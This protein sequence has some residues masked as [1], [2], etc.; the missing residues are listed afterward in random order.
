MY[1]DCLAKADADQ[2][3]TEVSAKLVRAENGVVNNIVASSFA[4]VFKELMISL[5]VS[6]MFLGLRFYTIYTKSMNQLVG[7][8]RPMHVLAHCQSN[9]AVDVPLAVACFAIHIAVFCS[10]RVI[11]GQR[12]VECS[13]L[14]CRG[15]M[16]ISRCT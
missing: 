6:G 1:Q 12:S 9:V 16:L 10:S 5:K 2:E 7:S 11:C 4:G 15:C 3:E 13:S 8:E 14:G